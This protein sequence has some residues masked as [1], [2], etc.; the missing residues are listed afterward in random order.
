MAGPD[1][2]AVH[3]QGAS[4]GHDLGGVVVAA[5][6]GAGDDDQQIAVGRGGP[7]RPRRCRAG[8]SGSI[9]RHCA[10]QPASRAWAASISEL[11]SRISPGPGWVPIG[12]Y[13][14]AGGEHD[15]PRAAP[16]ERGRWPGGRR[17]GEID[18]AQPVT[19]GQQQLGCADV[20]ADRAH[21]LIRGHGRP[22]LRAAVCSS[23]R[24]RA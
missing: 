3:G 7:R 22:Q 6:A 9:G 24:A 14:V 21:V 20:L 12:P 23:A 19:L 13:L 5:G 10:S 16:D 2:D 17:G 8:S 4:C 11:V 18:R 1:R 15:D